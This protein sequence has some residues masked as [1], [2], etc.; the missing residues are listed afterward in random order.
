MT[1]IVGIEAEPGRRGRVEAIFR[2]SIGA[3]LS[4]DA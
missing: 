1:E 3:A 2:R 4:C